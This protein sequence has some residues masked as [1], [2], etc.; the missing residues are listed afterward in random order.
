MA[1]IAKLQVTKYC[2]F[3]NTGLYSYLVVVG[4]DVVRHKEI[5]GTEVSRS[6]RKTLC[7]KCTYMR[8]VIEFEY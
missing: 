2:H 4:L 5:N 3:L 1:Q 8:A 6:S 7:A